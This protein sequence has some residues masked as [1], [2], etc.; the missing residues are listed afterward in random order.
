MTAV[1]LAKK[2]RYE[3]QIIGPDSNPA[4]FLSLWP[5]EQVFQKANLL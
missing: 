4:C 1:N 5:L 2:L 3:Q